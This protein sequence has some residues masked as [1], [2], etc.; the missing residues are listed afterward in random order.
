MTLTIRRTQPKMAA[1]FWR[2]PLKRII[3]KGYSL[4]VLGPARLSA[5]I[6]PENIPKYLDFLVEISFVLEI[7]PD[8]GQDLFCK[9]PRDKA[10]PLILFGKLIKSTFETME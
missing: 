9:L 3:D 8:R 2:E 1:A 7:N 5:K 6:L 4:C 10:G